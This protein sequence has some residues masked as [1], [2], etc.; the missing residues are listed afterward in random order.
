MGF[1][2]NGY[3]FQQA[4][5]PGGNL[6]ESGS[7]LMKA[8]GLDRRPMPFAVHWSTYSGEQP[9]T[10]TLNA[11]LANLILWGRS[12]ELIDEKYFAGSGSIKHIVIADSLDVLVHIKEKVARQS[13]D[14]PLLILL[15]DDASIA[16]MQECLR[17]GVDEISPCRFAKNHLSKLLTGHYCEDRRLQDTSEYLAKKI[18]FREAIERM[19]SDVDFYC[20][21]LRMFAGEINDR[22]QALENAWSSEKAQLMHQAHSIKGVARSLGLDQLA[23]LAAEAEAGASVLSQEPADLR[24][25]DIAIRLDAELQTTLYQIMRWFADLPRSEESAA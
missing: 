13:A 4:M 16:K 18:L 5:G 9:S 8:S 21:L 22:R 10:E 25:S 19:Q 6:T 15:S 20:E 11:A 23:A 2:S 12:G 7:D 17:L 14:E 24:D 3:E 1:S